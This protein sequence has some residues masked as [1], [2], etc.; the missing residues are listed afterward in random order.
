MKF[1]LAL[2]LTLIP[3]VADA[4]VVA[5]KQQRKKHFNATSTNSRKLLSAVALNAAAGTRTVTLTVSDWS[6]TVFQVDLT[7]DAATT[8][9]MA[10]TGSLN[11]GTS[12]GNVNSVAIA[13]GVGTLS[14]YTLTKTV[15]ASVK[16]LMSMDTSAYDSIACVFGGAG[17]TGSDLVDVYAISLSGA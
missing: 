12:Y 11:G 13:A 6:Q 5:P 10:C 17:A 15:G 3:V 7:R 14:T 9:T 2:L 1:L 4:Q 16:E 8:L